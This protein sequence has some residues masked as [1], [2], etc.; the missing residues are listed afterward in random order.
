MVGCSHSP[1]PGRKAN[2]DSRS[3][4]KIIQVALPDEAPTVNEEAAGA[5]LR[6]ILHEYERIRKARNEGHLK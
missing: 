5:L 6:F 4:G 2:T 1:D 3:A